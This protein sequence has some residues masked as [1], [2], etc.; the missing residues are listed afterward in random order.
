MGGVN[1][2]QGVFDMGG[3]TDRSDDRKIELKIGTVPLFH[4]YI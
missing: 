4:L 1:V 3:I 2:C